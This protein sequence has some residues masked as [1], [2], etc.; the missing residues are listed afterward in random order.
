MSTNVSTKTFY[1]SH[2]AGGY[3]HSYRNHSGHAL[4][5]WETT[6]H[7]NAVSHWLSPCTEWSLFPI[8]ISHYQHTSFYIRGVQYTA[9]L[10]CVSR[11]MFHYTLRAPRIKFYEVVNSL[12]VRPWWRICGI[13]CA[14]NYMAPQ[15]RHSLKMLF[16]IHETEK[17][18]KVTTACNETLPVHANATRFWTLWSSRIALLI[19]IDQLKGLNI[20]LPINHQNGLN[21]VLTINYIYRRG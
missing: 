3:Q 16:C 6:L 10:W 8:Q 14:R 2:T 12:Q 4:S 1:G 20:A 18:Q 15:R 5:Q 13:I 19:V 17:V 11:K 9:Q 21:I 7:C